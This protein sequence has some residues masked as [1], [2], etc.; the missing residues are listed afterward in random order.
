MDKLM[1]NI[2]HQIESIH[3]EYEGSAITSEKALKNIEHWI[4]VYRKAAQ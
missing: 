4:S 2:K 3:G 1:K